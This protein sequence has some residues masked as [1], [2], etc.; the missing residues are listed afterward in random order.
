[1]EKISEGF[2]YVAGETHSEALAAVAPE[3]E[4]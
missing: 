3:Y 4:A 2:D 1:L